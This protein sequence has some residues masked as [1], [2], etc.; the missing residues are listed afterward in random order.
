[1]EHPHLTLAS[2]NDTRWNS[3]LVMIQTALKQRRVID[4]FI[5]QQLTEAG[6]SAKE[7]NKLTNCPLS[8]KDWEDLAELEQILLPFRIATLHCQGIPFNNYSSEIRQYGELGQWFT[9]GCSSTNGLPFG[10][11]GS[12][13]KELVQSQKSAV[14]SCRRN[15]AEAWSLL[16]RDR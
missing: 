7:S 6:M 10:T 2:D 14:A 8:S 15:M 11:L 12:P 13:P 3:A 9:D 16:Q 5:T 4:W 1:M